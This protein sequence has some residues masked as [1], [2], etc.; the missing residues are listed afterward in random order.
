MLG[1]CTYTC[2]G[3]IQ[4]LVGYAKILLPYCVMW[5]MGSPYNRSKSDPCSIY[6][7]EVRLYLAL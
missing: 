4:Y 1:E 7:L 5:N 2:I 3:C 6:K